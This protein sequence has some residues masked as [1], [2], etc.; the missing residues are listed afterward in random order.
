MTDIPSPPLTA[1]AMPRLRGDLF[2]RYG[3]FI[4][5][6]AVFVVFASLRPT[7]I[8]PGNIH[9]MLMSA[10]IAALMFLGLTLIVAAGEIDVS[11]MSVAALA[12]MVVAAL[13]QAGQ[14]WGIGTLGGL[15]VGVLF[16]LLNAG[17]VAGL[18]LP[19]LVITIATGALAA[20]IAAAIGLG[21]S[22]SLSSTGF[23]G[24]LLGLRLGVVPGI[25]IIVGLLYLIAWYVQDRLTFGHYIYAMEQNRAAVVEAGVPVNRMLFMLYVLSGVVSALAG[26][27]LA[28]NLSSGQPYLGTSYFLDGL[29]AVLLG[30]MALKL[31]KPNVI[32]TLAAVIFLIGLLNGAALLGWTDSER[33]IVRGG[34]LL[35]GVGLV[36]FARSRTRGPAH[37]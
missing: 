32:G 7:F 2:M 17:L 28:A 6:I 10:S 21:T 14:G 11:F 35:I 25:A 30:G 37:S 1:G 18:R 29:T 12:N 26:I 4:L 15:A 3:F 31:G 27:L 20:S 19:A 34:L 9:G 22:I 16:G 13:V 33:Q 5:V 8:A 24:Q 23:V 36:V